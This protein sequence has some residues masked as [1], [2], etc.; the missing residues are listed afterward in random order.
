MRGEDRCD[1]AAG[2]L[3]RQ[4]QQLVADAIAPHRRRVVRRVADGFD[5]ELGA[6]RLGLARAAGPGSGGAGP[7]SI[8]DSPSLPL[9]R[10][11]RSSTVSAWSSAVWPVMRTGGQRG[12]P[13]GAGARL[14]VRPG[15]RRS[16]VWR[17]NGDPEP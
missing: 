3:V 4:R 11:R 9:P 13:G 17:T 8:A 12:P 16:T 10:R 5:P 1:V 2:D 14:E 15:C 6:H 7:G